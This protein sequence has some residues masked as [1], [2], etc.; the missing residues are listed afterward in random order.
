MIEAIIRITALLVTAM[1]VVNLAHTV[2]LIARLARRLRQRH[3]DRW[4]EF[5]LPAWRTPREALAWLRDWRSVFASPDPVLLAIRV[6]AGAMMTRHAQLFAGSEAW[7]MMVAL[8][9]TQLA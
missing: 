4:L 3:P 5:W 1:A 9:V 7:A 2:L 8:V 6:D